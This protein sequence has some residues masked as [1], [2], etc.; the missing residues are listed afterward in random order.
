LALSGF[1]TYFAEKR[2]QVLGAAEHS[3]VKSLTPRARVKAISELMRTQNPCL[4]MPRG[5]PPRAG[6]A[7]CD[8]GSTDRSISQPM[9]TMKF[10]NAATIA[11]KSISRQL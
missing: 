2:V 8:R 3:Y 6:V 9:I 5:F 1:Y 4:V 10:I 7:G 11:L